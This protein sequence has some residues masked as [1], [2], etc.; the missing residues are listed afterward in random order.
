MKDRKKE[1]DNWINLIKLAAVLVVVLGH[2]NYTDV[3]GGGYGLAALY[4]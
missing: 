1:E 3:V 2:Y 4:C